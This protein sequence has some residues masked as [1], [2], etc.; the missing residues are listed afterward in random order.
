MAFK[1]PVVGAAP[2][3]MSEKAI[4]IGMYFVAS[5]ISVVIGQPLPVEGSALV[6]EFL[7]KTLSKH[8][9]ATWTFEPDPL[10]AAHLM[11]DHIDRKRADLGL[12]PPMYEVPYPPETGRAAPA[13]YA[14][15]AAEGLATAAGSCPGPTR[16]VGE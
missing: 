14:V 3:W 6:V 12:P 9:G 1:L 7:T 2:E 10:K 4:S 16:A 11:I 5:G 8:F 15:P 13:V